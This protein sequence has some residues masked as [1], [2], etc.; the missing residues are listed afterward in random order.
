MTHLRLTF[1]FNYF[2]PF[3]VEL[4]FIHSSSFF[5]G[6]L[7]LDGAAVMVVANRMGWISFVRTL[8]AAKRGL[9]TED[10]V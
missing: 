6:G 9:V 2:I 5:L 8:E 4:D 7:F 10:V 1:P 3:V